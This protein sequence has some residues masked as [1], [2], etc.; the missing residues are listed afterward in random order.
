MARQKLGTGRCPGEQKIET[1]PQTGKDKSKR[2]TTPAQ[3]GG[4][5]N[6]QRIISGIDATTRD[7]SKRFN[8]PPV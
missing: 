1:Y 6:K 8:P 3:P 4:P 2:F 5:D 7:T